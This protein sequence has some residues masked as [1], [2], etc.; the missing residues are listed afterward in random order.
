MAGDVPR[1]DDRQDDRMLVENT[2]TDIDEILSNREIEKRIVYNPPHTP[3]SYRMVLVGF[4]LQTTEYWN[5]YPHC[6][7]FKPAGDTGAA[8]IAAILIAY[9]M[10]LRQSNMFASG[11]RGWPNHALLVKD[12]TMTPAGLNIR[13]RATKMRW[14]SGPP[15]YSKV[16]A[17]PGSPYCPTRA[18]HTYVSRVRPYAQG[19]AFV[20]TVGLPLR[21]SSVTTVFHAALTAEGH[22]NTRA[23]TLHLRHGALRHV[24]DWECSSQTFRTSA[25]GRPSRSTHTCRG[26]PCCRPL[27]HSPLLLPECLGGRHDDE[28]LIED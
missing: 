9:F 24:L 18:W 25:R 26:M 5:I 15:R 17:I 22:P 14:S 6:S 12:V 16:L 1:F 2:L 4:W 21:A 10:L 13:V 28:H 3:S 11:T 20:T 23:F 27:R 19:H 7:V 8:L